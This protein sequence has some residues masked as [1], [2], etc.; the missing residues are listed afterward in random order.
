VPATPSPAS[1]RQRGNARRRRSVAEQRLAARQRD[2]HAALM[3]A[4]ELMALTLAG[5]QICAITRFDL[6]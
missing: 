2:P 3:H 4:N 1:F 5:D 6:P